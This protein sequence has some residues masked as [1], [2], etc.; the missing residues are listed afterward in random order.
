MVIVYEDSSSQEALSEDETY[1]VNIIES[2]KKSRSDTPKPRPRGRRPKKEIPLH[3]LGHDVN[4]PVDDAT[5]G[6]APK[7]R[8]GVKVPYRNLTSQMVS[9]QEIENEIMERGKK[10]QQNKGIQIT[11][12]LC[13][14]LFILFF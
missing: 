14:L 5:N 9:R 4:K 6:K 2:T 1:N 12:C 10:R 3:I 7:P 13:D 11:Y 8:L